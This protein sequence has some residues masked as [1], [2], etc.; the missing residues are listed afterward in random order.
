[1]AKGPQDYYPPKKAVTDRVMDRSRQRSGS[2][3]RLA[4]RQLYRVFSIDYGLRS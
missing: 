2:R 3:V 1:M 4:R